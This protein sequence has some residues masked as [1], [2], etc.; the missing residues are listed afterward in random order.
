MRYFLVLPF[1]RGRRF[2]R[3]RTGLGISLE[4]G[5]T[6]VGSRTSNPDVVVALKGPE[7]SSFVLSRIDRMSL[8]NRARAK[9]LLSDIL[10]NTNRKTGLTLMSRGPLRTVGLKNELTVH[11]ILAEHAGKPRLVL[12]LVEA[13]GGVYLGTLISSVPETQL[14]SLFGGIRVDLRA[15]QAGAGGSAG[16]GRRGASLDGQLSFS[17]PDGLSLRKVSLMERESG[18]VAVIP[19]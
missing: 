15:A 4:P 10:S 14:P 12:G 2:T 9:T 1:R 7:K 8:R 17:L 13:G 18:V 19:G 3:R 11:Y 6:D 16:G 5:W